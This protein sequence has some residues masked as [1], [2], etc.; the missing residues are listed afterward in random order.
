MKRAAV[1]GKMAVGFLA[2]ALL[3]LVVMFATK[4]CRADPSDGPG[5]SPDITEE[6]ENVIPTETGDSAD[7]QDFE[8]TDRVSNAS[9]G[10]YRNNVVLSYDYGSGTISLGIGETGLSDYIYLNPQCSEAESDET[11]QVGFFIT[12]SRVDV[13]YSSSTGAAPTDRQNIDCANLVLLGQTYDT[14][15]PAAFEDQTA[16]GVRW[17]N[18]HLVDGIINGGTT[19]YIRAV[20]LCNGRLLAICQAEIAYDEAA[21]EYYLASLRDADVLVTGELDEETRDKL[22]L[23][24]AHFM[25]DTGN[26]LTDAE[27]WTAAIASAKVEKV[28]KPYF[29]RFFD[30]DGQHANP[31]AYAKCEVWAVNFQFTT[32]FITVYFAPKLQLLGMENA[33]APGSTDRDLQPMGYDALNPFTEESIA[34]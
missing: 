2:I 19:L 26:F 10:N 20:N 13:E 25:Q 32:G 29:S 1:I 7:I 28:P 6:E 17:K 14:A 24:A 4:S 34:W 22:V 23:D 12:S 16:Y 11:H 30:A 31:S 33:T 15:V 18:D 3:C 27:N 5:D 9:T 8:S 21:G